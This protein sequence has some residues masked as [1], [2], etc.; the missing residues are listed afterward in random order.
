MSS[1]LNQIKEKELKWDSYFSIAQ[2]KRG[3]LWNQ[4]FC[5]SESF[6][7]FYRLLETYSSIPR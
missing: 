7:E 2:E 1:F 5:T 3:K 4:F 6:N